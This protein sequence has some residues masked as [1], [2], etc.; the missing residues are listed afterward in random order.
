VVVPRMKASKVS[1]VRNGT[2][3]QL[4]LIW[5]NNLCS[6]RFHFAASGWVVADGHGESEPIAN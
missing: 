4:Q 6:M 5:L 3:A 2:P 1:Q